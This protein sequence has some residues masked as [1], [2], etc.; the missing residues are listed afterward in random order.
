MINFVLDIEKKKVLHYNFVSI[1]L[2]D[3]FGI[4][5]RGGCACAGPLTYDLLEVES[6]NEIV[7]KQ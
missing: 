2:N 6:P 7:S 4:Q 1:L 3:L 5:S